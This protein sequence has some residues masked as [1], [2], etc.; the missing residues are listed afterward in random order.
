[1]ACVAEVAEAAAKAE[2]GEVPGLLAN[3]LERWPRLGRCLPAMGTPY[4]SSRGPEPR[5]I[6]HFSSSSSSES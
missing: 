6:S 4:G 5:R 1:M 2:A 3:V